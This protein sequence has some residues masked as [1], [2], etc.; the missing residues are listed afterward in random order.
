MTKRE[1]GVLK[2]FLVKNECFVA[3]YIKL[4]YNGRSVRSIDF[5]D[6]INDAFCWEDTPQGDNYWYD[7]YK[8]WEAYDK[9]YI[10]LI[11]GKLEPS[12]G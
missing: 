6:A 2:Q 11:G 8:R 12:K 10:E 3:Y 7:I 4:E 1:E 5:Y 9:S